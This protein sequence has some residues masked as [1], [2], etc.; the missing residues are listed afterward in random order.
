MVRFLCL[1]LALAFSGPA[2]A[3]DWATRS[4]CTV[5]EAAVWPEAFA[6]EGL[7][8]LERDAGAY[9]NG[10]GRFWRVTAPG[11]GISH[12]WGTFHSSDRLILDLPD[13]VKDSIAQARVVALEIDPVMEDRRQVEMAVFGEDRFRQPGDLLDIEALGL[14]AE[15]VEWVR[16]RADGL[17]LTREGVD[18]LTLGGL[19]E[20]VLSDPCEDFAAGVV[21]TQDGYIQTLALIANVPVL[22]LE[23]VDAFVDFLNRPENAE[24]AT[25]IV[26]TL[27]GVLEP[28]ADSKERAT[29][30]S[31][32]LR[33]RIGLMRAWDAAFQRRTLGDRAQEHLTRADGY[34]LEARNRRFRD[35]ARPELL[36]GGV[37]MAVGSFHLSGETGLVDLLRAEGFDVTRIALPGEAL[38]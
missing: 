24:T 6:P 16:S 2:A 32:Y 14:P 19:A 20:M 3:Q 21:P 33:G 9:S 5:D 15:V 17:G 34:L 35:V 22:G 27:A 1:A 4:V 31:L 38:E 11:G 30:F 8:A 7:A 12:L 28:R 37:F 13:A 36:R 18:Y 23:P 10:T 26:A 25:S 29:A